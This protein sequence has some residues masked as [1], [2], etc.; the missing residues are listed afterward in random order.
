MSAVDAVRAAWRAR[1]E[2]LWLGL[3]AV[4]LAMIAT[5]LVD[6]WSTW[7]VLLVC[8]WAFTRS[9][10]WSWLLSLELG[11]VGVMW[12]TV[13]ATALAHLPNDRLLVG[14]IWTA[15]PLA[16]AGA[17]AMNRHRH[18]RPEAYFPLR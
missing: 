13:G 9:W 3:V 12:A 7:P 1:R 4:P 10:R 5:G 11:F 14:A 15:F 16:L 2:R 18:A 17:G 6:L 8:A